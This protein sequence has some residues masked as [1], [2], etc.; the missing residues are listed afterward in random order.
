MLMHRVRAP[1]SDFWKIRDVIL[2]LVWKWRAQYYS[3][4]SRVVRTSSTV[5]GNR[6]GMSKLT[7]PPSTFTRHSRKRIQT[8][9][10]VQVE[11][12]EPLH[13]NSRRAGLILCVEEDDL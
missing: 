7:P 13:G 2:R 12:P 8:D 5:L 6:D 4:S 3:R 11:D 1:K 10:R 9:S